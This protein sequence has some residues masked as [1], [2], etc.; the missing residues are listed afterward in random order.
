MHGLSVRVRLWWKRVHKFRNGKPVCN[1][2]GATMDPEAAWD[3][4]VEMRCQKC[5]HILQKPATI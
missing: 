4:L 3:A 1:Q 2:V 5:S